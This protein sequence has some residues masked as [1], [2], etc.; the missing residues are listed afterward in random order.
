VLR[1]YEDTE[2]NAIIDADEPAEYLPGVEGPLQAMFSLFWF[3]FCLHFIFKMIFGSTIT[4][5]SEIYIEGFKEFQVDKRAYW[6]KLV[7]LRKNLV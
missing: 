4:R 1:N 7:K 5:A 3:W 6:K 2:D